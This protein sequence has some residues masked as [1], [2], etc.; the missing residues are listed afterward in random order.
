VPSAVMAHH[1]RSGVVYVPVTDA[2]PAVISL[3]WPPGRLSPDVEAF[4][5]VARTIA[6]QMAGVATIAA[7]KPAEASAGAGS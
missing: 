5:R 6:D 7:S 1:P 4:L 3:A 2:E